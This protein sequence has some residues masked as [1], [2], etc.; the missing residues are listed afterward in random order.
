V[1]TVKRVP[2]VEPDMVMRVYCIALSVDRSSAWGGNLD[3]A[4]CD[5]KV[6]RLAW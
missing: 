6:A 4:I 3:V 5:L 1:V 2:R